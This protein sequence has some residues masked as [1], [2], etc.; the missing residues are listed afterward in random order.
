MKTTLRSKIFLATLGG[1]FLTVL[2]ASPAL[3]QWMSGGMLGGRMCRMMDV[4]P[5]PVDPTTLP[6]PAS[7]G[8][9]ILKSKCTQCHGLVSPRQH[10]AQDWPYIVD[11]MDRR[12]QMMAHGRMG[13]GMMRGSIEPLYPEEKATLT[14]YLQANAF[15]ALPQN[16]LPQPDQSG[17]AA[18][19]QVCSN[20]HALPDPASHTASEWPAVLERMEIN[21]KNMG[22][23]G[24]PA[25]QKTAILSYLKEN[26]RGK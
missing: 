20:C 5:Q 19:V 13:M 25:E 23:G 24:L 6:E 3:A 7:P 16:A 11:R 26:G 21:M 1:T 12:M 18:F 4:S 10:A 8:A 9:Q 22:F 14:A 15:M 17:A 2:A